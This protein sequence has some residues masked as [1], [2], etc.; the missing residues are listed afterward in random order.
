LL[1]TASDLDAARRHPRQD[2]VAGLTVAMVALPLALAFGAASGLGAQ[3]GL[4]TAVVAG[5]VAAVLGGSNLQVSGPTGAMTVVLVPVVHRFGPSAVLMV[6]L[7]AGLILVVMAFARIGRYVRFLP[8]PVLEGFTAGIAVVI[9]LQQ[10]PAALGVVDAEGDHVWQ[11]AADAIGR[12]VHD[13]GYAAPVTALTVAGVMLLGSRWRP[14]VPFSIIAIVGATAVARAVGT[15]LVPLGELPRG[16]PSPSLG[17]F[18][19][20]AVGTLAVSAF[21]VAA[22]AA[23]ESLLSAT[24]ADGMSVNERHDPDREL[25]GQGVA[26]IVAPVFGGIPATAAI[27]RTAVNVRAG[28]RSRLAAVTHSVVLLVVVLAFAPLVSD[29]PLAALAGVLFATCVRMVETGALGVLMTSSRSDALIV[30]VTFGVT[31]A[32]DLVTAVCIGVG[33]AVLL[34]LRATARSAHLDLAPLEPGEH[35]EEEHALLAEQIVAY[36]L[37][38]PLFFAAAHRMLLDLP[39]IARVRIVILRMSRVTTMDS[40][41]AHVLGDAIDRLERR[42]IVVLMSGIDPR[43]AELLAHLGISPHLVRDGLVLPGTPEAIA[44]ARELLAAPPMPRPQES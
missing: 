42:G 20:G 41:G 5:I 16:L 14:G 4:A 34:A 29:I 6:G 39:D 30:L 25:F 31:V 9:A 44:R 12:F 37:D 26:N 13:P 19:I 23:L 18:D 24:V 2:L 36:R 32:V 10:V 1:P 21:V 7:M 8:L 38:G 35:G 22:L 40:T 3:A 43:H 33:V 15:G 11:V 28:A 27:A 17:F